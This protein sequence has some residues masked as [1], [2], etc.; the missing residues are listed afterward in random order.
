[1]KNS[2]NKPKRTTEVEA[3]LD[4]KATAAL[5]KEITE[6]LNEEDKS[7]KELLAD[8]KTENQE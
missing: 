1:M 6:E 5:Q 2:R 4:C 7:L 3:I 8:D